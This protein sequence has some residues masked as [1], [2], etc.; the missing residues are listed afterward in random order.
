MNIDTKKLSII[1]RLMKV[2]QPLILD[3]VDELLQR[4]EMDARI[5]ES[6]SDI[7]NNNVVSIEQFAKNNQTWLKERRT[8]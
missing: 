7:E 2:K 6:I 5:E 4:S 1:E 3:E 8:K